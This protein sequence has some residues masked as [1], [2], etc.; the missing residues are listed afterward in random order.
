MF[1]F[2]WGLGMKGLYLIDRIKDYIDERLKR[3]RYRC[4]NLEFLY[5][6]LVKGN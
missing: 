4:L 6:S 3:L 2:L 1:L 5:N